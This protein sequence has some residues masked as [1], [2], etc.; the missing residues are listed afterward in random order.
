[1]RNTSE[2]VP[3]ADVGPGAV[4]SGT[5]DQPS[6]SRLNS[7]PLVTIQVGDSVPAPGCSVACSLVIKPFEPLNRS[8]SNVAR[9]VTFDV[10]AAGVD[11]PPTRLAA[12]PIPVA[13]TISAA[14]PINAGGM[15][16]LRAWRPDTG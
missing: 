4:V 13:A 14:A 1:M 6:P 7:D 8:S 11:E 12:T 9:S 16:C 3:A 5:P 2:L 15:P 10:D